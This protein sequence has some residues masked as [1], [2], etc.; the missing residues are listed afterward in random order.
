MKHKK[1][2]KEMV[3]QRRVLLSNKGRLN[4]ARFQMV[5]KTR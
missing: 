3:G 4:K 1:D 5:L 2:S